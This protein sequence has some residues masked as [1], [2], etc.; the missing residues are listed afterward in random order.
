MP[1][2]RMTKENT[3]RK[4]VADKREGMS[5]AHLAL[6]R[7][8]PCVACGNPA[9]NDAH[10]LLRAEDD[11]GLRIVKSQSQTQADKWAIPLCHWKCHENAPDSLHLSGR[12]G[13]DEEEWL[14]QRGIDGR[15]LARAL[16]AVRGDFEAMH[17]V[18]FRTRQVA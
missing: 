16:W 13:I 12:R 14:M 4:L 3:G 1:P 7:Q 15:A 17:R 2:A 6:I 11:N 8:L 10:H 5:S 18:I 9:P